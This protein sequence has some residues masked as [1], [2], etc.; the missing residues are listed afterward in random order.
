MIDYRALSDE[1]LLIAY[2][3]ESVEAIT[4]LTSRYMKVS[5]YIVLSLGVKSAETSDLVQEGMIGFLSAVYSYSN[6]RA[7]KF[8][9][10]ASTCMRNRIL[11]LL[12]SESSKKHIPHELIV[13]LESQDIVCS[14]LTPEELLISEQSSAYISDMINKALT[15][16]QQKV[17]KLYLS[18][19]SYAEI[20]LECGISQKA[21]D[22]TLQ[23]ARKKLRLMLGEK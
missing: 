7:V 18:G 15:P 8:S 9:T 3:K 14:T 19:L 20:S 12:R 23:R 13:S 4:E 1:D 17:F 11:S 22:G 10:Y 6:D 2:K 5:E 21:V 16:Q